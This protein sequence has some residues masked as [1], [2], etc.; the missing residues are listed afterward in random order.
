MCPIGVV[1]TY[2]SSHDP[3][4]GEPEYVASFDTEPAEK[5]D[6]V[7][8]HAGHCLR[9]LN[10]LQ[11]ATEASPNVASTCRYFGVC[12][13]TFYKW[14]RRHEEQGAAGLG[15]HHPCDACE[16]WVLSNATVSIQPMAL[17]CQAGKAGSFRRGD[18]SVV[19]RSPL[20]EHGL[21]CRGLLDGRYG[22]EGR[23]HDTPFR[24][25]L[26]GGCHLQDHVLLSNF[27]P[28]DQ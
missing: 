7:L 21:L 18:L 6:D 27:S 1:R 8:G 2:H 26:I 14:K 10:V 4:E 5:S 23:R 11:R 16:S 25:V 15:D 13:K 22:P 20:P 19:T 12:R 17:F 28:E 24:G 9:H 3:A